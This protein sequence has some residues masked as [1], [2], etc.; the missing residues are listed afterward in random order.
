MATHARAAS[1]AGAAEEQAGELRYV[2]RQP[3]MDLHGEA[4]GYELLFWN[5]RGPS[6]GA[7]GDLAT[8]TMLD[9]T[10]VFGLEELTRGLPAFVNC[11]PEALAEDWVEVLPPRMTIL[12]LPSSAEAT[13]ELLAACRK[14]KALG[15]RLALTDYTGTAESGPLADLADYIK[16]DILKVNAEERA[17]LLRQLVGSPACLVAQNVET[18]QQFGQACKE[19]FDLFQGYYFCR[20]EPL[21]SHKIPGN[22]L[23]HLEILEDLQN[24]PLDLQRLSQLVMCDASLTY[25][26]LRLVNSPVCAMRQEVTSVQSALM[27]VG[28]A[29]FRR[30]AMLAIASDFSTDQ[31]EEILRMAFERGRF[32]ELAAPLCGLASNEQYL[33]GMVSLFPAM[34]RILMEDLVRQ[35]PLREAARDALLGKDTPEGMLLRWIVCQENGNWAECDAIIRASGMSHEQAMRCHA[36]AVEWA[37]AA[38]RTNA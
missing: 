21:E 31:P 32:C 14:L 24:D 2:A 35:L 20:P 6:N 34:L 36:L 10:V 4:R 23:V 29:T 22:R 12:E 17:N 30:I 1:V 9:N 8:R 28:D 38:L 27:L 26:L 3:I 18:Q 15:F 37:E 33:I 16:V 19:G 7:K 25:R 5:G 11:T 13:P